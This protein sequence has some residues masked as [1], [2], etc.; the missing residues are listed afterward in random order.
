MKKKQMLFDFEM[1]LISFSIAI[2]TLGYTYFSFFIAGYCALKLK[3]LKYPAILV[4][5]FSFVFTSGTLISFWNILISKY[6]SIYTSDIL[7][8]IRFFW[9]RIFFSIGILIYVCRLSYQQIL[10]FV[11][12]ISVPLT[13]AG[14]FQFLEAP[15]ER[16]TMLASEHSAA[17]MYYVF[18][19]PLLLEYYKISKK[20]RFWIILFIILGLFIRSKAQILVLP[21]MLLYFVFK[22]ENKKLKRTVMGIVLVGIVSLPFILRIPQ[23]NSINHFITVLREYGIG[24]LTEKNQIWTSFTLRFSSFL[25]AVQLFG[26]NLLGTG[27][28]AFHPEYILKM[29]SNSVQAQMT[30]IEITGTLKNELYATPKAIFFEYLVSCGLFFL[31]PIIFLIIR[32]YKSPVS[33]LIKASMYSLIIISLMVELSPFLTFLAINM[34]LLYK[35]TKKNGKHNILHQGQTRIE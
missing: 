7:Y 10:R 5:L 21:L 9:I 30:G 8:R 4:I 34:M 15:F 29:T 17:G 13:I 18:M 20:S 16:V 25:T 3:S 33:N 2:F 32:F 6:D 28:G 19:L 26:E 24:G 31:V 11:Y 1:I 22:S 14:L 35:S 27:F 23:L 12:Y